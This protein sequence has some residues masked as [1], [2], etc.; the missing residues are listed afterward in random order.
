MLE[1]IEACSFHVCYLMIRKS[2]EEVPYVELYQR[3]IYDEI[4]RENKYCPTFTEE[5]SRF[6]TLAREAIGVVRQDLTAPFLH[7]ASQQALSYLNWE[8]FRAA[9]DAEMCFLCFQRL[10]E[11]HESAAL[12]ELHTQCTVWNEENKRWFKTFASHLNDVQRHVKFLLGCEHLLY[13]LKFTYEAET[14]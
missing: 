6:T 11:S 13:P 8:P 9:Y 1:E 10:L 12:Q 3:W 2:F 7:F 5:E 14:Y 4:L